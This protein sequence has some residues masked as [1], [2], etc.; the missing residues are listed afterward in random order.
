MPIEGPPCHGKAF[1]P[2][3]MKDV[4]AWMSA[5]VT[6][7]EVDAIA[8]TGHSGLIIAG[9]VS[10]LTGIPVIAVRRETDSPVALKCHRLTTDN[11]NKDKYRSYVIVDD[12]VA[13]G[14][15]V[16]NIVRKIW[17]S[18]ICESVVPKAV[19]LYSDYEREK[20]FLGDWLVRSWEVALVAAMAPYRQGA[21]YFMPCECYKIGR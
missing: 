21:Q 11:G 8:A 17:Q 2:V 9:A 19:L 14:T 18:Q 3:A 16:G 13:S 7:L 1:N 4:S 12:M 20:V 10:V 6:A 5:R 15:T